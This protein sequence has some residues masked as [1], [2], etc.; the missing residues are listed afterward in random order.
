[1]L[2]GE[3]LA[4]T[5]SGLLIPKVGFRPLIQLRRRDHRGCRRRARD[6]P[7]R[8]RGLNQLRVIDPLRGGDM[9]FANS[10]LVIA[11]QT[12]VTWE[13][14]GIVTAS[15]M[16]CRTL[17]GALAVAVLGGVLTASVAPIRPSRRHGRKLL[18]RQ[19]LRSLDPAVLGARRRAQAFL[20][21]GLLDH[22]RAWRCLAP[23]EPLVSA[24]VHGRAA[25][26]TR[27]TQARP[28]GIEVWLRHGAE[29]GGACSAG[30][31]Q[32]GR[33]VSRLPDH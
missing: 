2:V 17:G 28:R 22:R 12:S 31:G 9:G 6:L 10:A 21:D 7:A 5:I 33:V 20:G 25:A 3:P 32:G 30:C 8:R 4:S 18:T 23:L 14:R 29:H 13:D 1:M 15:T 11:L 26:R 16:F 27:R 24:H 19:G